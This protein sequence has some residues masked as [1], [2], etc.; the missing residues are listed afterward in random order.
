MLPPTMGFEWTGMSYQEAR[1]RA[2]SPAIFLFSIVL[3]YLVL[4]APVR[5]LV[6]ARA[7]VVLR[8]C[9]RR[10][11][12]RCVGAAAARLRQQRL[13]ADRHRAADRRCRHKTAILIVEFAKVQRE[14]GRPS[15]R[16]PSPARLR[17][18]AVLMTAFSFIL[19]VIPLL[20]ATGA[21]AASRQVLGTVVVGGHGGRPRSSASSRCRC[22]STRFR[23]SATRSRVPR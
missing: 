1:P 5:E 7:A 22:S 2:A 8:R 6:D 9:R 23:A 13:H 16:P 10:S 17:F 14:E 12:A 21:G 20:I 19:G 18:R 4:A 3:V 11:S 15:S